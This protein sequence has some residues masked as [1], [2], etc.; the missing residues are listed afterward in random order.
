MGGYEERYRWG[1]MIRI[2]PRELL[3]DFL[4][5]WRL[6]HPLEPEQLAF[7]GCVAAVKAVSFFH[8]G[9]ALYELANVPG[10]WHEQLLEPLEL[11][12]I[13]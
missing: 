10:L 11:E 5:S 7:G 12:R 2:A 3:E 13:S 9:D 1:T 6:H 4:R 8:G